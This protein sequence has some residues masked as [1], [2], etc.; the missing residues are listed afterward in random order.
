VPDGTCSDFKAGQGS[1]LVCNV[2]GELYAVADVCTHDNGPLG[3]SELDGCQVECP[4]HGA[5]FDVRTG[6]VTALPAVRPIATYAVR[7]VD[8]VIEVQYR[9]PE[10]PRFAGRQ[11]F[12]GI[13]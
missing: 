4:R 10:R 11:P 1:V 6:K 8:G 7:V 13:G 12:R 5:R 3:S 9:P 2:Q